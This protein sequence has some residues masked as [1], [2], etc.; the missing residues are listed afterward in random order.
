[1]VYVKA[2]VSIYTNTIDQFSGLPASKH[3]QKSVNTAE[4]RGLILLS[5]YSTQQR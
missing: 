5:C 1:M 3:L 2:F 4:L